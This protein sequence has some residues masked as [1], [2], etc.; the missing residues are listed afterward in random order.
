MSDERKLFSDMLKRNFKAAVFDMDGTLLDSMGVWEEVDNKFLGRRGIETP[1]DY[2]QALQSMHFEEAADYT[3]KRFGLKEKPEEIIAEWDSLAYE[4]FA[5]GVCLKAGAREYLE[6]LKGSGVKI[7]AAT[8]LLEKLCAAALRHNNVYE[9]FEAFAYTYEVKRGKSY[10]DIYLLAAEKGDVRA[11][12]CIVFEDTL[13]GVR[14][15][16]AAGMYVCAVF[17]GASGGDWDEICSAADEFIYGF[18]ELF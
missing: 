14:G 4:E 1:A 16:K 5:S 10:P 18:G 9:Y 2:M 17:D 3:I 11:D 12:E 13:T 15:A 8:S 7:L 6:Y